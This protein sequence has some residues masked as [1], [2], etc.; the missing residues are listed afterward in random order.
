M[1]ERVVTWSKRWARPRF[2]V[3]RP[4]DAKPRVLLNKY[5]A[6]NG[7]EGV[8][9]GICVVAFQ[10]AWSLRWAEPVSH[11]RAVR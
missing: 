11:S 6:V 7:R 8:I 1:G 4:A 10:R 9:V 2:N 5:G 3:Y